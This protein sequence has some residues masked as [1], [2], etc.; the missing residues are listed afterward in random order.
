M[1]LQ[2]L[3]RL[4]HQRNTRPTFTAQAEPVVRVRLE[5]L[6]LW[7]LVHVDVRSKIFFAVQSA[8]RSTWMLDKTALSLLKSQVLLLLPQLLA[9]WTS[10]TAVG[11]LHA[12]VAVA[13]QTV[14]HQE[15]DLVTLVVVQ[16]AVVQEVAQEMVHAQAEDLPV[17]PVDVQDAIA[18]RDYR[19][20][21]VIATGAFLFS[22][23]RLLIRS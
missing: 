18:K 13:A 9:L 14:V 4:I 23:R 16:T 22:S 15:A 6:L 10:A 19:N 21:P 1:T 7:F 3:S 20:A 5:L 8:M 17:D 2:W 12:K 11:V